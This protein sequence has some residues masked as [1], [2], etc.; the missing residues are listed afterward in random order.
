MVFARAATQVNIS[1]VALFGVQLP[2]SQPQDLATIQTSTDNQEVEGTV[3][4]AGDIVAGSEV[5]GA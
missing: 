1:K 4:D 5:G 3:V 2:D